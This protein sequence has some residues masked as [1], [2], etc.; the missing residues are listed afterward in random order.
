MSMYDIQLDDVLG[1]YKLRKELH[2]ELNEAFNAAGKVYGG[3]S[4][5][6]EFDLSGYV[7]TINFGGTYDTILPT[8]SS[9]AFSPNKVNIKGHEVPLGVK[10]LYTKLDAEGIKIQKEVLSKFYDTLYKET[11]KQ[12]L[13]K[14][15]TYNLDDLTKGIMLSKELI[16]D[17]KKAKNF[18]NEGRKII[19]R[20]V[21]SFRKELKNKYKMM[22]K[23]SYMLSMD[24][25]ISLGKTILGR[26]NELCPIET[27]FLRSSGTLYVFKDYIKILYRCPYAVYVHENVNK[28]H[29][30]GQAKFLETAVQEILSTRPAY[31]AIETVSGEYASFEWLHYADNK[32]S[33][34]AYLVRKSSYQTI[35]ITIDRNLIINRSG[36][37]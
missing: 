18:A 13:D 26:S 11:E 30:F 20:A 8:G 32:T 25:L 5:F 36:T 19:D 35:M 10:G 6:T 23:D 15:D 31:V 21:K 2:R 22:D 1:S 37:L 33:K 7:K 12:L 27:G 9:F 14:F 16:Y 3:R 28:S 34:D 4:F 24:Q 17:V 29:P